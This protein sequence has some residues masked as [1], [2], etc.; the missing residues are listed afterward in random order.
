MRSENQNL[1]SEE[2]EQY[3]LKMS[4]ILMCFW[5]FSGGFFVHFR[6]KLEDILV[7]AASEM[8]W[9]LVLAP[10]YRIPSVRVHRFF[11]TDD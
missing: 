10:Q 8:C 5:R 2:E 9:A 7:L 1:H 3:S 11:L 4:F 6:L